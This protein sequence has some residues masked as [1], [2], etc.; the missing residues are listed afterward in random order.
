MNI[1]NA[2]TEWAATYDTCANPT[3]DLDGL[4]LRSLMGSDRLNWVVEAGCG[5]GKNTR[6]FAQIAQ[7]VH[8]LDFSAGML[9]VA[10]R[11]ASAPQVQFDE[12]DLS[13]GWPC[14]SGCADLVSFNL[15]LEHINN[16]APVLGEAARVL[17]PGGRVLVSELHPFKQ[18]QSSQARFLSAAGTEVKVPAFTHHVSD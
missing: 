2:Y 17:R 16:L 15:V 8:A 9:E 11:S 12:A 10:R 14:A 4:A 5:T 18:Y 3:R 1:A 6:Y 13:A 7:R